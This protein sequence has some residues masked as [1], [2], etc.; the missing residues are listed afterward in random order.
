MARVHPLFVS[1]S[2]C[3]VSAVAS[4]QSATTVDATL[5][6]TSIRVGSS[7][8]EV[9]CIVTGATRAAGRLVVWCE[10]GILRSYT[11]GASGTLE[12]VDQRSAGGEVTAVFENA[13]AAWTM[14]DGSAR[15]LDSLPSVDVPRAA[16]PPPSTPLPSS[17]APTEPAASTLAAPASAPAEPSR[18]P[19]APR[20]RY[21]GRSELSPAPAEPE[22]MIAGATVTRFRGTHAVL[23]P[24][25]PL[26]RG[27]TVELVPAEGTRHARA[28]GTVSTV[29][30]DTIEVDIGFGEAVRVGDHLRRTHDRPTYRLLDPPEQRRTVSVAATSA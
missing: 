6:P 25:L 7:V 5:P 21:A 14:V 13:G 20:G 22:P 17:P 1:L 8:L 11:P 24:G 27:D 3:L 4:A 15:A 19:E 9:G 12:L 2:L 28:V 29:S 16:P 18:R 26:E 10:G 30:A 23:A